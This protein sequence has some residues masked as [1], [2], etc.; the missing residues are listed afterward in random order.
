LLLRKDGQW[1]DSMHPVYPNQ[2]LP[3]ADLDM[4]LRLL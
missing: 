1:L 4:Q 3:V 2:R